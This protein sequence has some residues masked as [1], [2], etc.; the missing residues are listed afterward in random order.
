MAYVF[1]E[2]KYAA[3]SL[4]CCLLLSLSWCSGCNDST[5]TPTDPVEAINKISG[6]ENEERRGD[7]VFLHGLDGDAF[8]TWQ[9]NNDPGLFWPKWLGEKYK[10]VGIWSVNYASSGSAWLG[11]SMPI[12]DRSKNLL[13]EMRLRGIGNRPVVFVVHSLGGLVVKQMLKDGMTMANAEWNKIASNTRGVVF[14]AT[15]NTGSSIAAIP[16]YL[17]LLAKVARTTVQVEQLKKNG[18]M[19]RDLNIWYRNNAPRI[20][21]ETR[22]FYENQPMPAI[23]LVVDEGSSDPGITGVTPIRIDENHS[24]ICKPKSR[25]SQVY[26]SVADFVDTYL[27]PIAPLIDI[28]FADFVK[29]FSKARDKPSDLY[30]FKTQ[31]VDKRVR[32]DVYISEVHPHKKHPYLLIDLDESS[33]SQDQVHASFPLSKFEVVP[34]AGTRIIIEGTIDEKTNLLG[35]MLYDCEIIKRLSSNQNSGAETSA[36]QTD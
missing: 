1:I 5:T 2:Q 26:R 17:G 34:P 21:I 15:P 31:Y 4:F 6:V 19:L 25:K 12:E 35:A 27:R 23:G 36:A 7:V 9:R 22:V 20:G 14:L 33:S 11:G 8:S 30:Q 18:P 24:T 28:T 16:E 32:W 29:D 3:Y 10:D 13:E